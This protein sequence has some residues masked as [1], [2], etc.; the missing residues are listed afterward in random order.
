M[1]RTR[2]AAR[3]VT[4]RTESRLIQQQ[5]HLWN[6]QHTS[7]PT[8]LLKTETSSLITTELSFPSKVYLY[9]KD[10]TKKRI[11]SAVLSPMMMSLS[12]LALRN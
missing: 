2:N 7:G 9:V 4:N 6:R 1:I 5:C 10:N 11:S 12:F 3:S 8:S